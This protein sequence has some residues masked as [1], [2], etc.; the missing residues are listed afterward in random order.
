MNQTSAE[1]AFAFCPFCGSEITDP[2][3]GKFCNACGKEI[4]ATVTRPRTIDYKS[5]LTVFGWPIIHVRMGPEPGTNRPGV[6]K[7]LI[8]IGDI[9]IGGF[10]VGGV[11]IGGIALG[12]VGIGMVSFAGVAVG[13]LMALGGMSV[14][15]G[16]GM[17]GVALAMF[18]FGGVAVGYYAMG[19]LAIGAV[20]EGGGQPNPAA[21]NIFEAWHVHTE[22]IT[23]FVQPVIIFLILAPLILI[24]FVKRTP[25]EGTNEKGELEL[26]KPGETAHQ[27]TG[28]FAG[29]SILILLGGISAICLVWL[30]L[31][32]IGL[33]V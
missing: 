17:G 30:V 20:A 3:E 24:P 4:P 15:G 13:L 22:D 10:A 19:G 28:T 27:A 32:V 33:F 5:R 14:S 26:L 18:A 7:G 6:A 12:G 23:S 2:A 29:L 11:S 9:A 21:R 31:V 1:S 25:D 8:A 16:L